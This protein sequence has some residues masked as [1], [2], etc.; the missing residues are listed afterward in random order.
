MGISKTWARLNSTCWWPGMRAMIEDYVRGCQ[1]CAATKPELRKPAGLLHPLPI[2]ER[3]WQVISIDFVG[4]LP[5]TADHFDMILVVVDKFSKMAHFIATFIEPSPWTCLQIGHSVGGSVL[6]TRC[7]TFG[8][9][10]R[11]AKMSR[12]SSSDMFR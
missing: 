1:T 5:K 6:V 12:R 10:W 4:P 9:D 3:P 2:P 8:T 7:F 11:Y